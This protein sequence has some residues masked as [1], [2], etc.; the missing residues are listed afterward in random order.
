MQNTKNK[1]KHEDNIQ[2]KKDVAMLNI[3]N[4]NGRNTQFH[5]FLFHAVCYNKG[6]LFYVNWM[7]TLAHARIHSYYEKGA[8]ELERF[9]QLSITRVEEKA[10]DAE[11]DLLNY[12][13]E[14]KNALDCAVGDTFYSKL[15]SKVEHWANCL[16]TVRV[17]SLWKT[18]TEN[19]IS[20][21]NNYDLSLY[22][23]RIVL[24]VFVKHII[25]QEMTYNF[26]FWKNYLWLNAVL[27]LLLCV[28]LD[29]TIHFWTNYSHVFCF[30]FLFKI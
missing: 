24:F 19:R 29:R 12:Y 18:K 16:D 26:T 10:A 4:S 2:L 13:T 6:P 7:C 15:E 14:L 11:K 22:I 9:I 8:A 20:I 5:L 1:V 3:W 21:N 27:R 23:M 17:Y 25:F 30:D 28:L